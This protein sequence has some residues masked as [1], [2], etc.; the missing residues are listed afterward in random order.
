MNTVFHT[1]V[2]KLHFEARL[3]LVWFCEICLLHFPKVFI[4]IV[5]FPAFWAIST[6]VK[7][8]NTENPIGIRILWRIDGR[9]VRT[10]PKFQLERR[11]QQTTDGRKNPAQLTI[12][13]PPRPPLNLFA[14]FPFLF[15]LFILLCL[16]FCWVFLGNSLWVESVSNLRRR[17]VFF[18]SYFAFE[19]GEL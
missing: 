19:F 14:F 10:Q 11:W 1:M 3:W 4:F 2:T 16:F 17:Y 8:E 18:S 13:Y 6:V 7:F 15:L 9:W 5:F 12:F